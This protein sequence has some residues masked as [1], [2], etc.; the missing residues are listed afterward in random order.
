MEAQLYR[1]LRAVSKPF[2]FEEYRKEKI[3]ERVAAKRTM[4]TK[5]K[6]QIG[7]NAK[8]KEKLET[9]R[10]DA[11]DRGAGSKLKKAA[12]RAESLLTDDRFA[13]LFENPDFEIEEVG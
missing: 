8:L 2:A 9:L 3:R 4:R 6:K 10:K 11:K 13:K 7:T 1:K 12:K 5:D